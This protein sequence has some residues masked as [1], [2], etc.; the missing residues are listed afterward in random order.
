[1]MHRYA[2]FISRYRVAIILVWVAATIFAM[3]T[4]PSLS[5]VVAKHATSELPNS[6]A[7]VQAGKLLD[8][9]NP[10]HTSK[11]SAVIAIYNPHGL[12][13][14]Q[15]SYLHS[16]LDILERHE[17]KYGV[18]DVQDAS[19]VDKGSQSMFDS[20]DGTTEIALVDFKYAT[21]ST[22]IKTSLQ[23]VH[24]LFSAPPAGTHVYLTG[25]APDRK[26]VV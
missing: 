19:S 22:Q 24:S 21:D 15:R 16:Q 9:I 8:K 2:K 26:S 6:S 18:V 4:L 11:S 25:D 10:K 5:Q 20:K 14:A 3:F 1:M 7:V 23:Q 12:T 13:S 17:A